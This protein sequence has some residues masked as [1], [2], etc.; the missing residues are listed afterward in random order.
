MGH[1]FYTFLSMFVYFRL[2]YSYVVNLNIVFLP[3]S[4]TK[5]KVLGISEFTIK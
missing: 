4:F 5:G 1:P 3:I 2:N